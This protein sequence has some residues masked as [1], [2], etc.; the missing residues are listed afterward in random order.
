MQ[1]GFNELY[2]SHCLGKKTY[3]PA[4][5]TDYVT[6]LR[7]EGISVTLIKKVV[8]GKSHLQDLPTSEVILAHRSKA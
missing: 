3:L 4:D 5:W 7:E 2:A 8:L 6:F 1:A